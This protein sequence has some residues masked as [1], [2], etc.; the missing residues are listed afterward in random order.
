MKLYDYGFDSLD[1]RIRWPGGS[2]FT[3]PEFLLYNCQ[4]VHLQD[5]VRLTKQWCEWNA[6]SRNFVLGQSYLNCG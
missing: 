3:L 1:L 2:S 6:S 4:Y 5:Y